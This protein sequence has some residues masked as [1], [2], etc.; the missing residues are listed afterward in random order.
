[1]ANMNRRSFLGRTVAAAGALAAVS[2]SSYTRVLGANDAVRIGVAGLNGRGE[3][4]VGAFSKIDGVRVAFLIDPD[5]RTFGRRIKQVEERGG[6]KP[7][8]F[9]D[10]RKALE[11]KDLDAVSI[12]TTNHWHS[13]ITIWACVA[14]KDVYVEKPL[15]HNLREGR[16]AVEA[17]RSAKRIVQHGTQSRGSEAWARAAAL[18]RSGKLGKLLVSRALC[19]KR[20]PSIG[21][22]EPKAPPPEVDFDLWL[23]PAS[24]RQY[25]ENLVHYNWHWF[26]DFGNGDIGNQGVHQMDIA[27]WCIPG[28][29]L[30]RSVASLGGRFGY[31]DQGET[32]NTQV[33]VMDFG[34]TLLIFEVRG[35]QAAK[36]RGESVGNILHFEA[37]TVAGGKLF[38]AGKETPEPLPEVDP[39]PGPPRGDIFR[40]FIAAVR[41]RKE[42]ELCAGVLE[43]HYSSAL[44]HLAN[45]SYRLGQDVPFGQRAK[46]GHDATVEE[47][48]G[49]MEEHLAK[50]N[51]IRLEG[52]TLRVGRKLVVDAAAEVITGDAQAT[53]L[54]TRK[55]RAPFTIPQKW[56]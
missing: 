23:G 24:A 16:V 12:A 54:L 52:M 21:V 4:H 50:E 10:I 40:N 5:R 25:H 34:E 33:A 27:R 46:D 14:G 1:M 20:R 56:A 2:A 13:L 15:S 18:A 30:P 42:N 3:S 28:A 8:T 36:Y 44:C 32:P 38:P 7:E 26:W 29:T 55:Y 37:G 31:V 47:T 6:A 39:E 51:G 43:G 49:R 17:A 11:R 53:G 45:I 9:Q 48:I 22:K 35:L 41:S 19:Y